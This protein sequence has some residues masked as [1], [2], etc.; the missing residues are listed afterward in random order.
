MLMD[1]KY[2]LRP[3]KLLNDTHIALSPRRK[4]EMNHLS[5]PFSMLIITVF[6]SERVKIS[7]KMKSEMN[8]LERLRLFDNALSHCDRSAREKLGSSYKSHIKG[9]LYEEFGQSRLS[10]KL[11]KSPR[12]VNVIDHFCSSISL[13]SDFDYDHVHSELKR[14]ECRL[15]DFTKEMAILELFKLAIVYREQG[16][17][18]KIWF[19]Y[20]PRITAKIRRDLAHWTRAHQEIEDL[21]I[22]IFEKFIENTRHWKSIDRLY[23]N[24]EN[25]GILSRLYSTVIYELRKYRQRHIRKLIPRVR[26][27][28]D[29]LDETDK[30][31]VIQLSQRLKPEAYVLFKH[32]L[33]GMNNE[34][35]AD[36]LNIVLRDV[37]IRINR[38]WERFLY[39]L[40][41]Y[42][43]E[44]HSFESIWRTLISEE[45]GDIW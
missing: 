17:W 40:L 19:L 29:Q 34:D 30:K 32:H 33:E 36:E 20:Q 15:R 4:N 8:T 37:S 39:I 41:R 18:E 3:R 42:R 7:T 27:N 1:E 6:I 25:E 13:T 26:S 38:S 14:K 2:M 9:W 11:L 12:I 10:E 28:F 5:I 16:A 31:T 45:R 44:D 22:L 21:T 23:S 35:I 43:F 24:K